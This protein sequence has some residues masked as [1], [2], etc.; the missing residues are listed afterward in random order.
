MAIEAHL[1]PTSTNAAFPFCGSQA[2]FMIDVHSCFNTQ[3]QQHHLYNLGHHHQ[4]LLNH[5]NQMNQHNMSV[6]DHTLPFLSNS[7]AYN[8]SNKYNHNIHPLAPNSQSFAVEFDAQGDEVDH[9][10]RSQ[11]EKFRI[12]LQNQRKQQLED[13]LKKV[14][15]NALYVLSQKDEQIAQATKKRVELEE[16]LTRLE[17][18]NQSWRRVAQENEAMVLSLHNTLEQ[19]KE[20]AFYGM[21]MEDAESCC[22]ENI[23]T[24]EEEEETGENRLCY[25]GGTEEEQIGKKTMICKSC[26]S[27][28]SSFMFLPC[29][30]LC[31][32]KSCEV[33][34][35]AC[36]VCRMAKKSSIETLIF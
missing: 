19:M 32:C 34:L 17:A 21:A 14:E 10:V 6:V 18:E 8:A 36:P 11:N 23:G 35:Q 16:F 25:G 33:F 24:E 7:N 27:R 26:N 15:L 29:R 30:H 2:D 4:H 12:L 3:Q 28:C 9:Y 20:R 13:F 1:Y 31:S 22:D 5:Q